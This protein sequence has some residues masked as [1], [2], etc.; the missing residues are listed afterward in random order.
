MV[1]A[2]RR[3]ALLV[4]GLCAAAALLFT[5][6]APRA[7]SRK[8]GPV[9]GKVKGKWVAPK[10]VLAIY[11]HWFHRPYEYMFDRQNRVISVGN[12][13]YGKFLAGI[14][15][16]VLYGGITDGASR[17]LKV[18]QRGFY[19]LSSI[20]KLSGHKIYKRKSNTLKNFSRFN[21]KIIRWGHQ[22]LVPQPGDTLYQHTYQQVYD[23][24]FRRFFRLMADSYLFVNHARSA[25]TEARAYLKAMKRRRFDG[26]AYLHRRYRNELSAYNVARNS[27]NFTPQMAIGFW[28]R[29]HVDGTDKEL[30]TGLQ[31]VLNTYDSV[32]WTARFKNLPSPPKKKRK[33]R[34]VKSKG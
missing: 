19:N 31:K 2:R 14:D 23:A 9:P 6:G 25:K 20:E 4:V 7:G 8:P 27:T 10:G 11:H 34:R 5:W 24:I 15:G 16:I 32:W 29:R 18:K 13:R 3:G 22:N 1:T 28:I 33:G 21:P 30:S 12:R 26:I 17:V